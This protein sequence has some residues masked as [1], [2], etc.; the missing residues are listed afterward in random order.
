[1][2]VRHLFVVDSNGD[3]IVATAGF[4]LNGKQATIV[5]IEFAYNP[6]LTDANPN[7]PLDLPPSVDSD[8]F[9][10]SWLRGYGNVKSLPV[11]CQENPALR[12]AAND[13]IE[14]RAGNDILDGKNGADRLYV[15][16]EISVSDAIVQGNAQ[17]GSGGAGDMDTPHTKYML[18][19]YREADYRLSFMPFGRLPA[20]NTDWRVV[21]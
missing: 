12:Q 10:L 2:M 11:A 20:A 3:A 1:M 17:T 18:T 6:A 7:R 8:I 14:G 15:D 21:A 5:D 19:F 9:G 13:L 16:G 4:T